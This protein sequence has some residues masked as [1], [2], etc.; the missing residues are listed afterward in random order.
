MEA[1]GDLDVKTLLQRLE[2]AQRHAES[3]FRLASRN[4]FQQLVGRSGKIVE[5]DIEVLLLE[6]AMIDPGR[7]GRETH[8][9]RIPRQLQFAWR[10]GQSRYVGSGFAERE[11]GKVDPRHDGAWRKGLRTERAG[12]SGECGRKPRLQQRAAVDR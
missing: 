11:L 7:N 6:K 12:R 2:P 3:G 9:A 5:F 4:R 1:C 8:R 10:A